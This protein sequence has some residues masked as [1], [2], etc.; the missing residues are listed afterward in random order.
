[1]Q[2]L[3]FDDEVLQWL[4]TA[5]LQSQ[6]DEQRF[7]EEAVSRLQNEYRLLQRRIDI[8]YADRCSATISLSV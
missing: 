6:A 4:K 7:R 3:A 2:R 5:M 8:M 1:M